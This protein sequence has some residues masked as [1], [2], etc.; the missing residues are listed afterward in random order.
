MLLKNILFRIV[1]AIYVGLAVF[2]LTDPT[3]KWFKTFQTSVKQIPVAIDIPSN[4]K[5]PKLNLDLAISPS[6]VEGNNW[7]VFDD[8][9]AWLSSSAHPGKGNMILYAHDR[10]GLFSDLYK[11]R[12]GDD[13]NIYEDSWMSYK[14]TEIRRVKPND[15]N[16][17]L[18]DRNR[19]TLYTCEGSFDQKRLV[20]YAE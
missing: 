2:R 13:I 14:V 20:V 1:V 12:R 19:L 4:I 11:L 16:S 10:K 9:V 8:R 17:I 15:V 6:V 18:S 7:E 3:L 5:I